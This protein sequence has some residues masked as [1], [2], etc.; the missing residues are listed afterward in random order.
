MGGYYPIEEDQTMISNAM[1]IP[2]S[3][4]TDQARS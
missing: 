1:S 3:E 4:E 2:P